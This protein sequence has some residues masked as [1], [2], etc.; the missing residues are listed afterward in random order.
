MEDLVYKKSPWLLLRY[1]L[2]SAFMFLIIAVFFLAAL[3]GDL[4]I[5]VRLYVFIVSVI[6]S[7]FFG[8]CVLIFVKMLLQH[9]VLLKVDE[10]GIYDATS[11]IGLGQIAWEDIKDISY[12]SLFSQSFIAINL[13]D[14]EAYIKRLNHFQRF[15]IRVNH[16][17]GYPTVLL[18]FTVIKVDPEWLEEELGKRLDYYS[19]K[20][21]EKKWQLILKQK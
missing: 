15:C 4:P 19:Q 20:W 1:F 2:L 14:D 6:S 9:S 18:S 7:L 11:Y 16:M 17:L 21:K 13:V 3:V 12:K 8:M 5:L 10:R